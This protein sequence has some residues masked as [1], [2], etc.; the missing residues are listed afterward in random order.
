MPVIYQQRIFRRDLQ[1]NPEVL[2][3]FGDNRKRTGYGGQAGEMRDEPNAVGIVTKKYPSIE[4]RAFLSDTEY[5]ENVQ[6]IDRDMA[7]ALAHLRANTQ[8]IVV[9][10][11]DGIGTGLSNLKV[12]APRTYA[13]LTAQLKALAIVGNATALKPSKRTPK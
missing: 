9:I 12:V 3:L 10:P 11:L 6:T 2:Y 5:E 4:T 8:A 1:S 13:Y 7:R